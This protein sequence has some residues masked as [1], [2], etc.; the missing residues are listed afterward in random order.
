MYKDILFDHKWY[1]KLKLT[2]KLQDLA[3]LGY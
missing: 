2:E 1:Y 3:S